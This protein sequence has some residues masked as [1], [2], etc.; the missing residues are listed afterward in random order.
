MNR[1]TYLPKR[2]WQ[3]YRREIHRHARAYWENRESNPFKADTELC[4]ADSVYHA[5]LTERYP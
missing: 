1:V 4:M 2:S 5:A 3:S